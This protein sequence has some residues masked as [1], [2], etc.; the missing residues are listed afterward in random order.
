MKKSEII[1]TKY[2]PLMAVD[3]T[4]VDN[5]G[6]PIETPRVYSL[7]RLKKEAAL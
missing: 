4:L 5:D 3:T 7:W 1:L 2:S 6:S